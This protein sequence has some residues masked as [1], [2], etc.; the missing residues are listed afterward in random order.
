[1]GTMLRIM[2]ANGQSIFAYQPAP[3]RG[4]ITLFQTTAQLR[5]TKGELTWGWHKLAQGGVIRIEVP[6]HHMN[7]LNDPHV[8][9]LA[10]KL[11]IVLQQAQKTVGVTA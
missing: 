10:E 1:M 9:V 5:N 11:R 3:Y 6:G 7:L 8:N 4:P 2:R